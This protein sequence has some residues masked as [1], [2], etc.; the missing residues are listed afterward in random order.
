[1]NP[2]GVLYW[3]YRCSHHVSMNSDKPAMASCLDKASLLGEHGT[4]L[5]LPAACFVTAATTPPPSFPFFLS[6]FAPFIVQY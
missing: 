4:Y 1:M 2:K 5:N 6:F 3:H